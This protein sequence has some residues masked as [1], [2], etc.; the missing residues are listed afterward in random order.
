M[1][2]VIVLGYYFKKRIGIATGLT[3]SGSGLGLFVLAPFT[4]YLIDEYSW[5]GAMLI[6]AGLL[7]NMCAFGALFR[8]TK[9]ECGQMKGI[10]DS[11]RYKFTDRGFFLLHNILLFWGET[12]IVPL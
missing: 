12:D 10:S 8:P 2:T 1:P 4:R 7:A 9:M 5:R 3:L 6:N 11:G